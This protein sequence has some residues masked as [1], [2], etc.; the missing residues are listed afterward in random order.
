MTS[1]FEI[2]DQTYKR[3]SEEIETLKNELPDIDKIE[4]IDNQTYTEYLKK[5]GIVLGL[6]KSLHL[7]REQLL[8]VKDQ[9]NKTKL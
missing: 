3:I 8:S 4:K 1:G 2:L 9:T 7:I 5:A 6:E